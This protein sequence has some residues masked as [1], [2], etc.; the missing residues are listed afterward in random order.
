MNLV[1]IKGRLGAKP[2]T[3]YTPSGSA[4]ANFSLATDDGYK[5]KDGT[6]HDK[7]SWHKCVAWNKTAEVI[8]EYCD[9]GS[10]IIVTGKLEYGEWEDKDGIK[11]NK[12]EIRVDR[13]EFCGSKKRDDEQHGYDEP[14]SDHDVPF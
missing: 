5:D 11:R 3:R 9:K 14:A 13:F 6:K 8:A 4:V 7:T 1:I 2:E 10:E 12:T